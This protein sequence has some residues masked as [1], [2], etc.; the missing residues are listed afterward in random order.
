MFICNIV[1]NSQEKLNEK[2]EKIIGWMKTCPAINFIDNITFIHTEVPTLFYGHATTLDCFG[3]KF[4]RTERKI[5]EH[6]YWTYSSGEVDHELWVEE[7]IKMC[8]IKWFKCVDNGIDVVFQK[9]DIEE[10]AKHLNPWPMIHEG[11]YEIYI[12]D[13]RDGEIVIH[14]IKKDTIEYLGVKHEKWLKALYKLLNYDFVALEA[15][16][17]DIF[18]DD[19]P[20]FVDDV[21]YANN[22]EWRGISEII[23]HYHGVNIVID[24]KKVIIFYLNMSA[25]LRQK[26]KLYK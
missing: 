23:D 26:F 4:S 16:Q 3:D 21:L 22:D 8:E 19:L 18:G 12:G 15:N 24:R 17:F 1:L 13:W 2:D 14:S 7:F 5:N 10:F 20:V 25:N 9:F 11:K 6:Y